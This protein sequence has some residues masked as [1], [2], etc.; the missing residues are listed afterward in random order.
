MTAD[1]LAP[2]ARPLAGALALM[3]IDVNECDN[4]S[5]E[6]LTE[7]QLKVLDDWFKKFSQKYTVM[8]KL[9]HVEAAG[10]AQ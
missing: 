3:K 4:D 1:P 2:P 5:L 6:G 10:G 7:K 8:G 9:Q